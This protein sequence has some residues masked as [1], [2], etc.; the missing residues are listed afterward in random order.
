MIGSEVENRQHRRRRRVEEDSNNDDNNGTTD[1]DNYD[2]DS[3][4]DEK[5]HRLSHHDRIFKG[6]CSL[7]QFLLNPCLC[8]FNTLK[9]CWWKFRRKQ[10]Q[11]DVRTIIKTMTIVILLMIIVPQTLQSSM[12][13]DW[14]SFSMLSFSSYSSSSSPRRWSSIRPSNDRLVDRIPVRIPILDQNKVGETDLGGWKHVRRFFLPHDTIIDVTTIKNDNEKEIDSYKNPN[15]GALKLHDNPP[16]NNITL[17]QTKAKPEERL[18]RSIVSNDE[19]IA[20]KYWQTTYKDHSM[21]S[22]YQDAES[23]EDRKTKCRRPSWKYRYYPSCNSFHEA[24]LSR[25]YKADQD[26]TLAGND[27]FFDSFFISHGYYRDVWVLHHPNLEEKSILKISRWKHGYGRSTYFNTLNDAQVMERLTHSPRIVNIYGHCGSAVWVEAMPYEVEEVV[28]HG[29][30]YLKAEDR[31]DGSPLE[32]F[33]T[34]TPAQKLDI[35][36]QMAESIADLHGYSGGVM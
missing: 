20:E 26:K 23:L 2:D 7:G 17:I 36:I 30:G 4:D 32:S 6:S 25:D 11:S 21:K 22:Y 31:K 8:M 1:D 3:E 5:G 33:S 15:F 28:I 12:P 9:S 14:F 34:Y 13:Q 10:Q 35:A 19:E 18:V 16:Y 24:D 27:Q 29:D